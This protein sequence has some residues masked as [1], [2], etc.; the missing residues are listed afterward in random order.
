ADLAGFVTLGY[1]TPGYGYGEKDESGASRIQSAIGALAASYDVPY[2]VD[3]AWGAPFIGSDPRKLGADV[4]LFSMDKVAGA[5]TS[6]LVIG[7]DTSMVN[8]RRALGFHSERFGT[9]SSHG[10]GAHASADPGKLR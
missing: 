3:N 10:K 4:M 5:P 9:I 8:V 1:D 7:R 6:G 2:V